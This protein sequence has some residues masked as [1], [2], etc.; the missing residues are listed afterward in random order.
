MDNR[1]NF[2]IV[3][4]LEVINKGCELYS[5]LGENIPLA[6]ESSQT[7]LAQFQLQ[8]EVLEI[9]LRDD[10]VPQEEKGGSF[11]NSHS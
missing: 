2:I 11:L 5:F 7:F 8:K 9:K 10:V 3:F 1:L 6:V 4:A